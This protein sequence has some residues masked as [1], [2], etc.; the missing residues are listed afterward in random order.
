MITFIKNR[1]KQWRSPRNQGRIP[2]CC[3]FFHKNIV[4]KRN[5]VAQTVDD[6]VY[7]D[8]IAF[9]D[10]LDP[11]VRL[12]VWP[13]A[14]ASHMVENLPHIN[15]LNQPTVLSKEVWMRNFRVTKF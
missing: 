10:V 4:N 6:L 7:R 12:F 2:T 5:V 8:L 9:Q 14:A 1:S 11:K 13:D 15:L 3:L